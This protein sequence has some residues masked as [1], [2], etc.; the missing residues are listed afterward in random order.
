MLTP[1]AQLP[2]VSSYTWHGREAQRN[3]GMSPVSEG[4]AG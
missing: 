2:R 4:T 3:L 1:P